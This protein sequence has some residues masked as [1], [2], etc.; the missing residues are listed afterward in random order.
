MKTE[1]CNFEW[2]VGSKKKLKEKLE[3]RQYLETK[4][5]IQHAKTYGTQYKQF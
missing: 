1:Q 3:I 5:K 2:P 4:M